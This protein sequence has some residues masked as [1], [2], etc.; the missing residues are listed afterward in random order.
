MTLAKVPSSYNFTHDNDTNNIYKCI[1]QDADI[2]SPMVLGRSLSS[3]IFMKKIVTV[4]PFV[5]FVILKLDLQC[6]GLS[7]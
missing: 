2:I 3:K 6:K 7:R 5:I 1:P 4:S